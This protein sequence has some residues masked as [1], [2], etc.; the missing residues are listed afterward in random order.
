MQ[1]DHV[2]ALSHGMS[3]LGNLSSSLQRRCKQSLRGVLPETSHNFL[4]VEPH[5]AVAKGS[6]DPTEWMPRN[7]ATITISKSGTTKSQ[8]NCYSTSQFDF[9][10]TRES[11]CDNESL[12]DLPLAGKAVRKILRPRF[13]DRQQ[14][15]FKK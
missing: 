12:P 15:R 14:S 13:T 5:Q 8:M 3:G 7:G 9:I 4:A 2:V 6:S 11:E 10:Q 1:I